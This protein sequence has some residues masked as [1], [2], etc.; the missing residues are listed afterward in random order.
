MTKI[1]TATMAIA[2]TFCRAAPDKRRPAR[3][4]R[5][6]P[7]T[8]PTTNNAVVSIEIIRPAKRCE[9]IPEM[10]T[11]VITSNDVPTA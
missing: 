2:K 5:N 7:A 1:A 6:S 10:L 11:N 8:P 3:F 9:A 4:P